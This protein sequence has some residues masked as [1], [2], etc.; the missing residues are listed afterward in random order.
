MLVEGMSLA[1][2]IEAMFSAPV[3]H[4]DAVR[5]IASA[6]EDFA[7]SPDLGPMWHLRYI[8]EGRR[9][10]F[11][12]V[13]MEIATPTGTLTSKDIWLRLPV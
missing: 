1:T 7:I 6:L 10:S 9:G 5:N 8:Y 2:L 13:N 3:P 4:R 12:V 11:R